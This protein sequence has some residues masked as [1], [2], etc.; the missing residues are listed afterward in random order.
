MRFL[1]DT[2]IV[3][4]GVL[5]VGAR[6]NRDTGAIHR[7]VQA[8]QRIKR[9]SSYLQDARSCLGSP[10]GGLSFEDGVQSERLSVLWYMPT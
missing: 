7:Q 5:S 8:A 4:S 1:M 10:C 9:M 3:V 6:L 2:L